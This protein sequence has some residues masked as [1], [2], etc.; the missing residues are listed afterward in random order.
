MRHI[1]E[2]IVELRFDNKDFEK[3][4]EKSIKTMENLEKSIDDLDG[5]ESFASFS[6]SIKKVTNEFS[7]LDSIAVGALEHIGEKVVDTGERLIKGLTIDQLSSGWSKYEEKTRAVQTIMS[8]TGETID[9]V[10]GYLQ[11]LMW[12]TDETSYNFVDMTSN[13]GKFTAQG[14]KLDKATDAMIGIANW[15]ALAGQGANEASRA[16]YNL[17]QSL[18]AGYVKYQDW[19]SVINANMDIV[20]F[21]ERVIETA[22]ALG[23]LDAAGKTAAGNLVTVESFG[24]NLTSDAWFTKDVLIKVLNEYG[25]YANEVYRVAQEQGL[26]ASEAMELVTEGY[27]K[28]SETAFRAAQEAKTF[29]DVMDATNDAASSAWAQKFE[30]IFGNFT[31]AKEM[32]TD[33]SNTLYD[34]FVEPVNQLNEL[35][36]AWDEL[37]GR[38][39][40]IDA[41][42]QAGLNLLQVLDL[43]GE[44]WGMA[45][46]AITAERLFDM[47]KALRVLI[48]NLEMT[49]SAYNNL[50]D[51]LAGLL[52]IFRVIGNVV[53]AVTEGLFGV[54]VTANKI[55]GAIVGVIGAL[56]R[57]L[58]ALTSAIDTTENLQAITN[59]VASGVSLLTMGFGGFVK[60]AIGAVQRLSE[61]FSKLY[62][63]SEEGLGGIAGF[64]AVIKMGLNSLAGEGSFLSNFLGGVADVIGA[65]LNQVGAF[66]KLISDGLK[67]IHG[68]TSYKDFISSWVTF[69]EKFSASVLGRG[70]QEIGRA[71]GIATGEIGKFFQGISGLGEKAKKTLATLTTGF[72]S[73]LDYIIFRLK[74]LSIMDLVDSAF[75]LSLTAFLGQ[76]GVFLKKVEDI[77]KGISNLMA[78]WNNML[79]EVS[80]T[81]KVYQTQIKANTFI[82]LA[83]AVAIL[84]GSLLILSLVPFEKLVIGSAVLIAFTAALTICAK[85]LEKIGKKKKRAEGMVKVAQSLMLIAAAVGVLALALKV[86]SGIDYGHLAAGTLV[87]YAL[88]AELAAFALV[89]SKFKVA[90]SPK[91]MAG[92]LVLAA[93]LRLMVIP[94]KALGAVPYDQLK[95]GLASLAIL[96]GE[97]GIFMVIVQNASHVFSQGVG[98]AVMAVGLL[99]LVGVLKLLSMM[100]VESLK[101]SLIALGALLGELAIALSVISSFGSLGGVGVMA[102]LPIMAVGIAELAAVMVLLGNVPFEVIKAGL[103]AFAGVM[104]TLVAGSAGLSLFSSGLVALGGAIAAINLSLAALIAS[105]SLFVSTLPILAAGVTAF[106]LMSQDTINKAMSNIEL[107]VRGLLQVIAS[108]GAELSAIGYT[109]FSA[110]LEAL[111]RITPHIVNGV[112]VLLNEIME[113]IIK[114]G[115]TLGE[116]LLEV[117][118]IV[119]EVFSGYVNLFV[120]FVIDLLIA[121]IDGV[122]DRMD[123]IADSLD[124][125]L[126]KLVDLIGFYARKWGGRLIDFGKEMLDN[127]VEGFTNVKNAI[128]EKI[129]N[130]TEKLGNAAVAGFREGIDAHS[131]SKATEQAGNDFGA[132]FLGSIKKAVTSFKDGC[133]DLGNSAVDGFNNGLF[134]KKTGVQDFVSN[135]KEAI[136]GSKP[137][138]TEASVD[139]AETA[140]DSAITSASNKKVGSTVTNKVAKEIKEDTSVEDAAKKK[141]EE[142][143]DVFST[144][145]KKIDVA[146]SKIGYEFDIWKSIQGPEAKD[147]V[148]KKGQLAQAEKELKEYAKQYQIALDNYQYLVD[149][150]ELVQSPTEV[151]EKQETYMKYL[152]EMY[153][154]AAE[155]AQMQKDMSDEYKAAAEL[156]E[157]RIKELQSEQMALIPKD[158]IFSDETEKAYHDLMT[159]VSDEAKQQ[160]LD[161][162]KE[163]RDTDLKNAIGVA[164]VNPEQVKKE[165]YKELGLDPNDAFSG[166]INVEETVRQLVGETSTAYLQGLEL[167]YP[168]LVQSYGDIISQATENVLQDVKYHYPEFELVGERMVESTETGIDK[169]APKIARAGVDMNT[170]AIEEVDRVTPQWEEVGQD[171]MEGIRRGIAEGRSKVIDEAVEVALA[172]LQAA[173]NALGIASPSK[174]FKELGG[175]AA[176]GLAL[177]LANTKDQ[178]EKAST[179]VADAATR[180]VARFGSYIQDLMDDIDPT[181]TPVLDLSHAE[182]SLAYLNQ[183]MDDTSGRIIGDISKSELAKQAENLT[184]SK[185][186]PKSVV[187]NENFTQ[188]NYSP[189]ALSAIEIYRQTNNQLMRGRRNLR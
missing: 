180:P 75:I 188:N 140:A 129:S 159:A 137:S 32:L 110:L 149:H 136:T 82:K 115:P 143:A 37:G 178:V 56:G 91:D 44:A 50:R 158:F 146:L 41:M 124:R 6:Q 30:I 3:E 153:K 43:L 147:S 19:M 170:Q 52:S 57:Y 25:E 113:A 9:T 101:K 109:F 154:K 142:V 106:A 133:K 7:I 46:P 33:L 4:A 58:L 31:I 83:T 59:A 94:L 47:T 88:M 15:A 173:K 17:A 138:I 76:T 104:A 175:F 171:M 177:G 187:Y 155:I 77:I 102:M 54:A 62:W 165:V 105:F 89:M 2:R 35:L 151:V 71:V 176:M 85:Q 100:D 51:A 189:K 39:Y 116:N 26:T 134:G 127:L 70:F 150:P 152:A 16:M 168:T 123:E 126:E 156:A 118:K 14:V 179:D 141:A 172:A 73:F 18:G 96:L 93:S 92:L 27:Q 20:S 166:Y 131:P 72:G 68:D 61:A 167:A 42:A 80:N 38:D 34:V 5:G 112:L 183:M 119:F 161:I 45:F 24:Q 1:D 99:E 182:A 144:E 55:A 13:I 98:L 90:I 163:L 66:F 111:V 8:S 74:E 164:P 148:I 87:L 63:D 84:A 22:K 65:V 78:P 97:L 120:K 174:K 157:E 23:T 21:K 64:V 121:V 145:F 81:L 69:G 49:E 185:I 60:L 169:S 162:W 28:F 11:K 184:A 130:V 107:A 122:T 29:S 53:G 108:M 95:A 12:F 10:N 128:K 79:K 103:L 40:L 160:Y 125:F 132:G 135:I 117:I 139:V 86:I 67:V 48:Y 181:I 36:F 114:W 186:E